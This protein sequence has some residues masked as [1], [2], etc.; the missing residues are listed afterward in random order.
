MAGAQPGVHAL[1]LKPVCVSDSLKKGTKFVKWD[2]VSI[3]VAPGWSGHPAGRAAWGWGEG[4]VT[5]WVH[6]ERAGAASGL[7]GCHLQRWMA[8]G[9]SFGARAPMSSGFRVDVLAGSGR[10]PLRVLSLR[11]Q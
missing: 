2:D 1:Q 4:R 10:R 6:W 9:R 3:G 5:Q 8:K 11:G 7:T